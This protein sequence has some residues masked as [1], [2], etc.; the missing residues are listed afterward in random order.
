VVDLVGELGMTATQS[1]IDGNNVKP[2]SKAIGAA[3]EAMDRLYYHSHTDADIL[4]HVDQISRA[5]TRVR[6]ET[7]ANQHMA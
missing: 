2:I 7:R 5:L 1:W 3:W 6:R 4:K